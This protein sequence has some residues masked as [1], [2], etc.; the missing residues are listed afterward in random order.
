MIG[1]P[2]RDAMLIE[3]FKLLDPMPVY[4]AAKVLGAD[5]TTLYSVLRRAGIATVPPREVQQVVFTRPEGIG[6]NPLPAGCS[7]SWDAI[8]RGLSIEGERFR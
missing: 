3:R 8:N 1:K 2:E 4:K 5:K 6:H 7:A